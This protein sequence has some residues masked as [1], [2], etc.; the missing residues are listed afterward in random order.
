MCQ[1]G[2]WF[3]NDRTVLHHAALKGDDTV[4]KARE[5]AKLDVQ[6]L[7]Q[8]RPELLGDQD[9][10]GRT[11][12]HL[13]A[14]TG[15]QEAINALIDAAADTSVKDKEGL[16]PLALADKC[17]Q[18]EAL[19]LLCDL[20]AHGALIVA[21]RDFAD[22]VHSILRSILREHPDDVDEVDK[23]VNEVDKHDRT[24]LHYA[25]EK[26]D[27]QLKIVKALVKAK[28]NVNLLDSVR[29]LC[30]LVAVLYCMTCLGSQVSW[31][32][33]LAIV[34]MRVMPALWSRLPRCCRL[35]LSF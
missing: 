13:A 10:D 22:K 11:A 4:T 1:L 27:E 20:G 8:E 23:R 17:K 26:P 32:S 29:L 34:L 16:T 30:F 15:H 28:A 3:Q 25:A 24:A 7:V 12:L 9:K 18:H 31:V 19:K 2:C 33:C 21:A 14:A 5:N 6:A 35:L